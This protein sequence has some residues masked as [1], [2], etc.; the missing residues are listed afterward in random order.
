MSHPEIEAR[1]ARA[2]DADA[3]ACAGDALPLLRAT[4]IDGSRHRAG[5]RASDHVRRSGIGRRIHVIGNSCSGKSS[6][7]HRL[8][9][10][11]AVPLVE[12]DA[13]H[14]EPDWV[15]LS[16]RDPAEFEWRL[17]AATAGDAWVVAGSYVRFSERVF[18]PRLETVIWLDLP[19]PALMTRVLTRSW[20]RWR[21]REVLW[22]TNVE[23]FWPQFMVWRKEESLV[24]W[25]A[26]QHR[27]KRRDMIERMA[28]PAWAHIRFVRL[29]S[30]AEIERFVATLERGAA[31]SDALADDTE[32]ADERSARTP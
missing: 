7:A 14:W 8:A 10:S 21:S 23:R 27:R 24:W 18:W 30:A 5:V 3:L 13:L 15:A 31:P 28:D 32:E 9:V 26:T 4:S 16:T 1:L 12:L 20:R 6:L 22:G 19:L 17:H 25:I 2:A 29:V 11:L